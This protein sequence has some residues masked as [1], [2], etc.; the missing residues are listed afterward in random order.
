MKLRVVN[1]KLGESR[2]VSVKR[3]MEVYQLTGWKKK[4]VITALI[5]TGEAPVNAILSRTQL[6]DW[7]GVHPMTVHNW[8]KTNKIPNEKAGRNTVY[9]KHKIMLWLQKQNDACDKFDKKEQ[10]CELS[11]LPIIKVA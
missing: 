11:P 4:F 10:E 1:I 6:A 5:P 2:I 8:C 3:P 7:L 9:Q